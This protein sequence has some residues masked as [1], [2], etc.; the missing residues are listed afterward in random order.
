SLWRTNSTRIQSGPA[1]VF[2]Y[3]TV[4]EKMP[5]ILGFDVF[6]INR[7][8]TYGDPPGTGYIYNGDFDLEAVA[9]AHLERGYSQTDYNGIVLWCGSVGCENGFKQ[10]IPARDPANIFGGDLGREFP[11]AL[12][13]NYIYVSGDL[14]RLQDMM[15][16]QAGTLES[17]LDIPAYLAAADAATVSESLLIQV[18]ILSPIQ[19]G[20]QPNIALPEA[21][22][23]YFESVGNLPP[24]ELV[25]L[26][27]KQDGTD[28]LASMILVYDSEDDAKQAAVELTQRLATFV[29]ISTPQQDPILENETIAGNMDEPMVYYSE[30]SGKWAAIAT[31]RYPMPDNQPDDDGRLRASG[32]VY[33]YWIQALFRRELT[34]LLI[35]LE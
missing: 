3:L 26:V 34:P 20:Y 28:Q 30:D 6:D 24:Y 19:V 25:A 15:D 17:Q 14:T 31:A 13:P 21:Y 7:A 1:E 32:L 22:E 29:P 33:R 11:F 27:D 18:Q 16:T 2:Q 35:K 9:A 12:T 8:L 4:F 10:N 23:A 5:Q